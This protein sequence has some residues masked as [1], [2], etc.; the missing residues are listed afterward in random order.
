[1]H[2]L[3]VT[4]GSLLINA[5]AQ[6]RVVQR[7]LRHSIPDLTARCPSDPALTP[8]VEAVSRLAD[9][10]AESGSACG[11]I[12]GPAGSEPRQTPP[13]RAVT[14]ECLRI[15]DPPAARP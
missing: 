12:R 3:R 13:G 10:E 1:M 6:L 9:F 14:E 15:Q 8:T 2:A 4:S 5:G 11:W 7:I